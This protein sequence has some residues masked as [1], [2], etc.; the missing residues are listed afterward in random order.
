MSGRSADAAGAPLAHE[1]LPDA[2]VVRGA[3]TAGWVR[4]GAT[5]SGAADQ[6]RAALARAGATLPWAASCRRRSASASNAN[7][8]S[9]RTRPMSVTVCLN[10]SIPR[11]QSR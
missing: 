11:S 5:G 2:E 3:P 7:G 9:D 4:L 10:A 8:G 6:L 1:A